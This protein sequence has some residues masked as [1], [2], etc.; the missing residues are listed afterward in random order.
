MGG[1]ASGWRFCALQPAG[2]SVTL[3][4]AELEAGVPYELFEGYWDR[5]PLGDGSGKWRFVV[6]SERPVLVMSL[7]SSP[8]GHLTNL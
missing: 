2:G 7:L 1:L 3:T 8:T 5:N 4:A 6:V